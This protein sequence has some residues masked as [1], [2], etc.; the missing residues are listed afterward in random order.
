MPG[1][2]KGRVSDGLCKRRSIEADG[3]TLKRS[4]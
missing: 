1:N 3:S 4:W 2:G